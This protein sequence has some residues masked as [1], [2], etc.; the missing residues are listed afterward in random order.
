MTYDPEQ[1]QEI[2]IGHDETARAFAIRRQRELER[3][4]HAMRDLR[5]PQEVCRDI[6]ALLGETGHG[7][8][9]VGLLLCALAFQAALLAAIVAWNWMT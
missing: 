4:N 2:S 8:P 3:H 6:N 5:T 1:Y 9:F 7:N